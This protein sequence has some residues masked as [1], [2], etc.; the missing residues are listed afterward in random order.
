VLFPGGRLPLRIFEARYLDMAKICLRDGSPFGVCA[1]REGAEVGAPAVPY[2]VGTFAHIAQWDMPQLGMLHVVAEG[3]ARFRIRERRVQRDGL[4][5]ATLERLA[6]EADGPIAAAAAHCARLVE[7]LIGEQPQLFAPPHRLA[8]LLPLPLHEK[9]A[10]LE[11]D[12]GA[13]RLARISAL[14]RA[15]AAPGS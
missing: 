5:R 10:L 1:I 8:E 7:R 12:D 13:A 3:A 15:T 14:L 6:E 11:L 4:A 2:E 9:Q